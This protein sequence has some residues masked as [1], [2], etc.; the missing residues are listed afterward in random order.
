MQHQTRSDRRDGAASNIQ[1]DDAIANS[2]TQRCGAFLDQLDV[3]T[4]AAADV[5]ANDPAVFRPR[6]EGLGLPR[7]WSEGPR[8]RRGVPAGTGVGGEESQMAHDQEAPGFS[9]ASVG[10]GFTK[11]GQITRALSLSGRPSGKGVKVPSL[12]C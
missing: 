7:I 5:P 12:P 10:G 9:Q 6:L 11:S 3:P 1:A 4:G 2:P 8:G